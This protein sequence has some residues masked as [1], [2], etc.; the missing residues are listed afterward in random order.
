M[1]PYNN[2]TV[3]LAVSAGIA[4]YKAPTLASRMK[5]A[6]ADVHVLMTPDSTHFIQPLAFAAVSRN[7]VITSIFP[8][9]HASGDDI[10]PHLYPALRSDIFLLAPATADVIADL[11]AGKAHHVVC[12]AALAL[13]PTCKRFFCP[14]MNSRMWEHPT[15][16]KNV[17]T[18]EDSGWIRIGPDR[19]LLACADE[20]PGRMPEPEKILQTISEHLTPKLAGKQILILSGPTRE[21]ID[22]V[23]FISN[24]SSGLMGKTLAECAYQSG[25]Q[26]VFVTG[27]VPPENLPRIPTGMIVHV[28]TAQEMLDTALR[29]LARA[30][31][32]L[33]VAAIADF[34]PKTAANHKLEKQAL[35]TIE[36]V[37]NPDVIA[38][39][40]D[41]SKQLPKP[42]ILIGFALQDVDGPARAS[43]KL[44]RK[45]LHAIVMN[46]PESFAA[47]TGNFTLITPHKTEAWGKITKQDCAR[48]IL[49][50][51]LEMTGQA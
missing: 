50:F 13:P 23:R 49:D 12:A 16:Q 32:V 30:D 35:Q 43:E 33:S 6:G 44:K 40:S 5:Q 26:V 29:H 25:A 3:I 18:L 19:G 14:A 47:Q 1:S 9:Q 38:T 36:L 2:K 17:R 37:P 24:L 28:Q 45:N 10:F 8:T 21:P 22:S 34:R 51:Y 4:A 41:H 20:G 15:V 42:P 31:L 7:Q 27:P 46:T 39:L 11:V 48:R